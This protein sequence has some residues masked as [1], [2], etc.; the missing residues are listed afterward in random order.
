MVLTPSL[1]RL[2]KRYDGG[3]GWLVDDPDDKCVSGSEGRCDRPIE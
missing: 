2:A 3:V 1:I